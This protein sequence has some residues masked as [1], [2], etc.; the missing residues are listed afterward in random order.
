MA[1]MTRLRMLDFITRAPLDC[2]VAVIFGHANAMNW[3]GASYNRVGLEVASSLCAAGYPADLFPSSLVGCSQLRVDEKGYVCLGPQRYRAI[4][5]YRPEFCG[6]PELE[7]F[8]RASQW[9]TAIFQVGEWTCDSEAHPLKTAQRLG[10]KVRPCA[11]EESCANAVTNWLG[12]AAVPRVTGWSRKSATHPLPPVDGLALLTD[13]TCIRAAGSRDAAG[14]PIRETFTWQGHA[15]EV[16]A[17]GLVAIRFASDGRVAAF[18]AGGLKRM[19][20]DGLG[21]DLPER[22][23]LAFIRNADGTCTGVLQGFAGD[24]PA[25]LQAITSHWQRLAVPRRV[26]K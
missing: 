6:E 5:L 22:A 4:V 20:T 23:D 24:V 10:D 26:A 14:D 12:E 3:A 1:A 19:K 25:P 15:V 8:S 17:I 11:D 16:D 18:A 21:L 7:F 2:P 13:G 9:K